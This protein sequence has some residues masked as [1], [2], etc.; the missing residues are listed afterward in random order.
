MDGG[1]DEG[2]TAGGLRDG[3]Q[4]NILVSYLLRSVN[5]PL[6]MDDLQTACLKDG[7]TN[8]FELTDAVSKLVKLGQ[9]EE[10]FSPD[11]TIHYKLTE[12]GQN[13]TD[14]LLRDLPRSV[15]DR[16]LQNIMELVRQKKS[17]EKTVS[18]ISHTE[19]GYLVRFS[20]PDVGTDLLDMSLFTPDLDS[21]KRIETAFLESPDNLYRGIWAILTGNYSTMGELIPP[22][23][24]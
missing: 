7:L 16:A 24:L 8:Y 13:R 23:N 12:K 9:V 19:D 1:F 3:Y 14:L 6:T 15:R 21:A 2:I 18:S 20:L 4:V 22:E 17:S 11:G 10:I 5:A